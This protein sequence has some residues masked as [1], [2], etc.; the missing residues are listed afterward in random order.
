MEEALGYS[1]AALSKAV[2]ILKEHH[3]IDV[4]KSATSNIYQRIV[5]E[6]LGNELQIR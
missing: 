3:Y 2:S 6:K 1:R 5:L 4:K